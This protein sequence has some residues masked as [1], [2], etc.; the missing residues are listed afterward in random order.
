M[1]ELPEKP[2]ETPKNPENPEKR[3]KKGDRWATLEIWDDFHWTLDDV[4]FV[5]INASAKMWL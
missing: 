3:R 2:R 5:I 4:L 1:L